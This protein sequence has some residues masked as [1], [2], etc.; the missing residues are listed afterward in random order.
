MISRENLPSAREWIG[1]LVWIAGLL[2]VIYFASRLRDHVLHRG[3]HAAAIPVVASVA[4]PREQINYTAAKPNAVIR[5]V[6]IAPRASD[7]TYPFYTVELDAASG[8]YRREGHY[9]AECRNVYLQREIILSENQSSYRAP[10][11]GCGP[12]AILDWL[13]WY[14]NSGLVPRS[15]QHSDTETYKRITYGLID[16]KIAELKGHYRTDFEGTNTMEIIVAFD[17]LVRELSGGKIRLHCDIKN[18]PLS[19]GDLLNQTS[20]YRA[21]ILIVQLYDPSA[22][23]PGSHHAVAVVRTDTTGRMTIANWGK[24]ENG[25]L[26]QRGDSQWFVTEDDS[27]PP[28][29]VCSLLT[30]IPFR[31]TNADQKSE[32]TLPGVRTNNREEPDR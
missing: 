14:Q 29:K 23:P 27:S 9:G 11:S 22:P 4:P 24:Y 10:S 15:T 32:K 31:P 5:T 30:F 3:G 6:P 28:M 8:G 7:A 16:R 17:G 13:I 2:V 12:T 19:R 21:G 26:V 1:F 20:H 18:A 25:Q